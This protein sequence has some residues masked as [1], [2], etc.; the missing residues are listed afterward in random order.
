MT[1]TTYIYKNEHLKSTQ[2]VGHLERDNVGSIPY[3]TPPGPS[4][5]GLTGSQIL[6]YYKLHDQSIVEIVSD[7]L[8]PLTCTDIWEVWGNFVIQGQM[9]LHYCL[10][11][12][13]KT[14][15]FLVISKTFLQLAMRRQGREHSGRSRRRLDQIRGFQGSFREERG[16]S[17][18]GRKESK[19]SDGLG[20]GSANFFYERPQSNYRRFCWTHFHIFFII[21]IL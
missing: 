13:G 10:N 9:K 14:E 3:T 18:L 16:S 6:L 7:S 2:L 1:K 15:P 21:A 12:S 17:E 5:A 11:L 19:M 8:H 20:W 4:P